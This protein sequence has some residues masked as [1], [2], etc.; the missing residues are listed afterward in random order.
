MVIRKGLDEFKF[1]QNLA[2][3]YLKKYC[4]KP[5]VL[6]NVQRK[7]YFFYKLEVNQ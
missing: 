4:G 5:V 1:K 6:H 2:G 7:K 3:I